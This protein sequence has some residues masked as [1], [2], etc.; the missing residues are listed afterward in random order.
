MVIV[1]ASLANERL[2]EQLQSKCVFTYFVNLFIDRLH[3]SLPVRE[4]LHHQSRV[5][6]STISTCHHPPQLLHHHLPMSST[7]HHPPPLLRHHPLTI[8]HY[9]H[10]PILCLGPCLCHLCHWHAQQLPGHFKMH[11]FVGQ[12]IE[13]TLAAVSP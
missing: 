13:L 1:R 9:H 6:L 3:S 11:L 10:P 2:V 5:H 8:I 7:R 12:Q 4:I